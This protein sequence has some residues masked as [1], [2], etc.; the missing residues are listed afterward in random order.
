MSGMHPTMAAALAP[1]A[2]AGSE[3]HQIAALPG[4]EVSEAT[5]EDFVDSMA[6]DLELAPIEQ[7]E[8]AKKLE[9]AGLATHPSRRSSDRAD[10]AAYHAH[11]NEVNGRD[12]DALGF[13]S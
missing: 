9:R 12:T 6:G 3:V 8:Q 1:F 5:H 7:D 4:L 2:P 10:A 13:W 11:R